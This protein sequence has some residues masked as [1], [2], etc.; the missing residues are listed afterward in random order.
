MQHVN[1]NEQFRSQIQSGSTEPE[2]SIGD[3][4]HEMS[5]GVTWLHFGF[6]IRSCSLFMFV[7][8]FF[9]FLSG[10]PRSY[11]KDLQRAVPQ[12]QEGHRGKAWSHR[13]LRG[14]DVDHIPRQEK[15]GRRP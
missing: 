12:V 14:G 8:F 11:E 2:F 3:K 1:Q 4:L 13:A 5:D 10:D 7:A 6:P 15:S 9:S